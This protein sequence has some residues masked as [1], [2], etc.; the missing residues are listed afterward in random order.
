MGHKTCMLR[1]TRG[2][3]RR[4]SA[5]I[6]SRTTN[7]YVSMY[8]HNS[9]LFAHGCCLL[10]WSTL[11]LLARLPPFAPLARTATLLLLGRECMSGEPYQPRV[12]R[13]KE[14]KLLP[15]HVEKGVE[16]RWL[17]ICQ[18]TST[19]IIVP[20]RWS[21]LFETHTRAGI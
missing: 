5:R 8:L 17:S 4:P 21:L 7:A 15:P 11:P 6:L 16:I 9:T 3:M 20:D 1:G 18:Q 2:M 19:G 12:P 10:D 13:D 14:F